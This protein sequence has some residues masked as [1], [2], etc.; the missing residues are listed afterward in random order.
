M[1]LENKWII[2]DLQLMNFND[3]YHSS[4]HLR[5]NPL[6]D[7]AMLKSCDNGMAYFDGLGDKLRCHFLRINLPITVQTSMTR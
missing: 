1:Y 3:L 2:L 6:G 5:S 4:A 7:K